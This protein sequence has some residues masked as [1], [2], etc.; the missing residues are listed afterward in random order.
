M[1]TMWVA[2]TDTRLERTRDDVIEPCAGN[3]YF[4]H[5]LFPSGQCLHVSFVR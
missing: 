1:H 2:C 4:A 5:R 3:E